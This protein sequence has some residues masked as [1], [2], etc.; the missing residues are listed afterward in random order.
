MSGVKKLLKEQ[1]KDFIGLYDLINEIKNANNCSL[2]EAATALLRLL[3]NATRLTI[4]TL[5]SNSV[6]FGMTTEKW[7][8]D[9]VIDR[10]EYVAVNDNF[11]YSDEI[12][13]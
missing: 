3:N 12:P 11:E 7:P 5:Y 8:N 4:P 13:F 6:Q 9:G 2:S 10:I 1:D